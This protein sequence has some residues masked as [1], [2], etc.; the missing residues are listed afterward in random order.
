MPHG[1]FGFWRLSPAACSAS[2]AAEGGLTG[3]PVRGRRGG[4]RP[5]AG[6]L[7]AYLRS[8]ESADSSRSKEAPF[9]RTMAGDQ[10]EE[11]R[12]K[13]EA[14]KAYGRR[15]NDFNTRVKG[16]AG[17]KAPQGGQRARDSADA[18]PEARK[19]EAWKRGA[20]GKKAAPNSNT[21][22]ALLDPVVVRNERLRE[23]VSSTTPVGNT[24]SP[25]VGQSKRT[26][27]GTDPRSGDGTEPLN[28]Q[29]RLNARWKM[30]EKGVQTAHEAQG[31]LTSQ[32]NRPG[33]G[34]AGHGQQLERKDTEESTMLLSDPPLS[35][36]ATGSGSFRL[37]DPPLTA[38][39]LGSGSFGVKSMSSLST[40][41]LDSPQVEYCADPCVHHEPTDPG[42]SLPR[43]ASPSARHLRVVYVSHRRCVH[44][45]PKRR[46]RQRT[47]R[48][49]REG[50]GVGHGAALAPEADR[51]N[52]SPGLTESTK[53]TDPGGSGGG[54]RDL[55]ARVAGLRELVA[56]RR[57]EIKLLELRLE[58]KLLQEEADILAEHI[59]RSARML[60]NFSILR[61]ALG[62]S[63]NSP[64]VAAVGCS[65][66]GAPVG[67]PV[68]A[69]SPGMPAA[70]SSSLRA[71]VIPAAPANAALTSAAGGDAV[72]G[73]SAKAD[74]PAP[75]LPLA[76]KS[77]DGLNPAADVFPDLKEPVPAQHGAH[78]LEEAGLGQ[79]VTA[80]ERPSTDK[81][82]LG[83][84]GDRLAR[85]PAPVANDQGA[86]QAL[87][88][89]SEPLKPR[90]ADGLGAKA[91]AASKGS[92][93]GTAL[94]SP[95]EYTSG[96]WG[97]LVPP[98]AY[99]QD[100]ELLDM[101]EEDFPITS[102][103]MRKD[104]DLD[105]GTL[106]DD[107]DLMYKELRRGAV[108]RMGMVVE[109]DDHGEGEV[110]SGRVARLG[111]W[112]G[113]EEQDDD[114]DEEEEQ[115]GDDRGEGE[116]AS[117]RVAPLGK[118]NG[119]EEQ[120][121]EEEG[122][123]EE[124]EL[125]KG[126]WSVDGGSVHRGAELEVG[127]FGVG[128]DESRAVGKAGW[129]AGEALAV[130]VGEASEPAGG[131]FEEG[132][133]GKAES[134][135][136]AGDGDG[137]VEPSR[138]VFAAEGSGAQVGTG[139]ARRIADGEL[140]GDE[141][142]VAWVLEEVIRAVQEGALV[143]DA[144]ENA[145]QTLEGSRQEGDLMAVGAA[146][147]GGAAAGAAAGGGGAA[148]AAE[149][150][151][152]MGEIG[153]F[154]G[155][156]GFSG[157]SGVSG[158][159][160]MVEADGVAVSRETARA[161]G[162]AEIVDVQHIGG[163][164]ADVGDKIEP[165]ILTNEHMGA[166][167][168]EEAGKDHVMEAGQN[169]T[170]SDAD[171]H[172]GIGEKVL[173]YSGSACS[174]GTSETHR[175]LVLDA[176]DLASPP[177]AQRPSGSSGELRHTPLRQIFESSP[178]SEAG[179]GVG[180]AKEAI[181]AALDSP[182]RWAEGSTVVAQADK[183]AFEAR[184][185][186]KARLALVDRFGADKQIFGSPREKQGDE[187]PR[188]LEKTQLALAT[189]PERLSPGDSTAQVPEGASLDASR[190]GSVASAPEAG[191]REGGSGWGAEE[192]G[193]QQVK[194]TGWDEAVF[195]CAA[196]VE[197]GNL[198]ERMMQQ[199][200]LMH[201]PAPRLME[202][203][204]L[205]LDVNVAQQ[206]ASPRWGP[207]SPDATW[208]GH[209]F[210]VPLDDHAPLPESQLEALDTQSDLW[211]GFV[212][213]DLDY[214]SKFVDDVMGHFLTDLP[215]CV[216]PFGCV[217]PERCFSETQATKDCIREQSV[218]DRCIFEAVGEAVEA[219]Y[220]RCNRVEGAVEGPL[221]RLPLPNKGQWIDNVKRHVL[222]A[223]EQP[224]GVDVIDILL[225]HDAWILQQNLLDLDDLI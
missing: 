205:V 201:E 172:H 135:I 96:S 68:P 34:R 145:V 106:T 129:D 92:H 32:E 116:A 142:E 95:P 133:L 29:A 49:G 156:T 188:E 134:G 12:Q 36:S 2:A 155:I 1:K 109:G 187:A 221:H 158:A 111:K 71:A 130:G 154:E 181:S 120:E 137:V 98:G 21:E 197:F 99:L 37:R 123:E 88:H 195:A 174:Q 89:P 13:L 170:H 82:C 173:L 103:D 20:K 115:E 141:A 91:L 210:M 164:V 40:A 73:T 50:W 150:E 153:G 14:K 118:W 47:E 41:Q 76:A 171:R 16:G 218:F 167:K 192:G 217:L 35:A 168:F 80:E 97:G 65:S 121:D 78:H 189:Q 209:D 175:E 77:P 58:E 214:I 215:D 140:S 157:A 104:Q 186:E 101:L 90:L 42:S 180:D 62:V 198:E 57:R 84:S 185:I 74:E 219:V 22:A 161:E 110:A 222:R 46:K 138:G 17:T 184:A 183:A 4:G 223:A 122:E 75:G 162:D 139:W 86:N 60:E 163:P 160:G 48:G 83:S 26:G 206:E 213:T 105:E 107:E 87:D 149:D 148:E 143:Q 127:D 114:D 131:L 11:A 45:L 5:S 30:V 7:Q 182:G 212:S 53:G 23:W 132:V 207:P 10:H 119:A 44:C 56:S 165:K 33:P 159:V 204:D 79:P 25:T 124:G 19:E 54:D 220:R 177:L 176:L 179:Q 69:R 6:S 51:E 59:A 8:I 117:G 151:K 108:A 203:G 128:G 152:K 61:A 52:A 3:S 67:S 225:T 55:G 72:V 100:P 81:E 146:G 85:S 102:E 196:D 194:P 112:G 147:G 178:R 18:A 24:S 9:G 191:D 199:A 125:V 126:S 200:M 202:P 64:R 113:A 190:V 208:A 144:A 193:E 38:S 169:D 216:K 63:G 27:S 166:G 15:V 43:A 28:F 66:P 39:A 31:I 70:S 94:P 136:G 224:A 93:V 211:V